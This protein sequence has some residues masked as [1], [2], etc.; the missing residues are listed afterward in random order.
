[1]L[2]VLLG[3]AEAPWIA[4]WVR[5]AGAFEAV[6]ASLV[7]PA[8]HVLWLTRPW[9]ASTAFLLLATSALWVS[10]FQPATIPMASLALWLGIRAAW[11]RGPDELPAKHA[12]PMRG[13]ASLALAMAYLAT[14]LRAYQAVLVRCTYLCVSG[15]FI[16][17]LFVRNNSVSGFS[18]TAALAEALFVPFAS[19]ALASSAGPLLR[20]ERRA[21]W[22]LASASVS[23]A[24][25]RLAVALALAVVA[26]SL[27]LPYCAV[28]AFGLELVTAEW[29]QLIAEHLLLG[30][31]F[32]VMA[33][34]V[35]RRALHDRGRDSLRLML[36][37]GGLTLVYVSSLVTF[38]R[39][40]GLVAWPLIA[41][42]LLLWRSR[43][44]ARRGGAAPPPTER[45]D[46]L[47]ISNVHKVLGANRVLQGVDLTVSEREVTLSH[48]VNGAGKS[49]L[50]RIIAGLTAADTGTLRLGRADLEGSSVAYKAQLGYIPDSSDAFPDLLVSEYV[51][52]VQGLRRPSVASVDVPQRWLSLL[53]VDRTWRQSLATLSFG[54]RK[55]LCTLTALIGDPWLLV[56]DEPSNGLDAAGVDVLLE[57]ISARSAKAQATLCCTNDAA[58]AARLAGRELWLEHGRLRGRDAK[59]R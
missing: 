43:R 11:A 57:L 34:G 19:I 48:G 56:F 10:G 53:G 38:D 13:P 23:P 29:A 41:A 39:S 55:R 28:L 5:G 4:L 1:M 7:A 46:M 51:A 2:F 27:A 42:G 18:R 3:L 22:V 37:M 12:W 35:A 50:L 54:Q 47:T 32:A 14:L 25:Q 20:T 15:A 58:F 16:A 44:D 33:E 30:S 40:V 36:G 9:R 6:A 26:G 24:R 17:Y 52:L 49:T 21:A 31:S 59:Q 45:P 8:L